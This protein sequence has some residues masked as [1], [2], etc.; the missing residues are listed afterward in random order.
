MTGIKERGRAG[1]EG[2][3]HTVMA[4]YFLEAEQRLVAQLHLVLFQ[5]PRLEFLLGKHVN[6]EQREKQEPTRTLLLRME[7]HE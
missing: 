4:E 2:R 6:A 5:Q 3:R 7:K 1:G